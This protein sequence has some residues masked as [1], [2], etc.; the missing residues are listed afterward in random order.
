MAARRTA[1]SQHR[2]GQLFFRDDHQDDVC[3]EANGHTTVDDC[4]A[5]RGQELRADSR[6]IRVVR[7]PVRPATRGRRMV[8]RASAIGLPA[9]FIPALGRDPLAGR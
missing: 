4:K 7:P 1:V 3:D 2:R 5:P 9:T 8:S 6:A